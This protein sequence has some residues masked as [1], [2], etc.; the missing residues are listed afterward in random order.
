MLHIGNGKR[1]KPHP[2]TLNYLQ[3]KER[4]SDNFKRNRGKVGL[5]CP[6]SSIKALTFSNKHK[7]YAGV[8]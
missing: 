2:V 1:E 3:G 5:R 4:S 8:F 7:G 6:S